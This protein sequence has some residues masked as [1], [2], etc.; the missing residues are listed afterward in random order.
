MYVFSSSRCIDMWSVCSLCLRRRTG[1]AVVGRCWFVDPHQRGQRGC[2][3]R[4]AAVHSDPDPGRGRPAA[5]GLL[6]A[7]PPQEEQTGPSRRPRHLQP[8]HLQG[9]DFETPF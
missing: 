6:H 2:R 7:V 9:Q 5:P 3:Q 8:L 1:G 4:G